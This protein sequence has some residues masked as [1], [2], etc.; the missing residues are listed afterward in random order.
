MIRAASLLI[1]T[2]AFAETRDVRFYSEN[3]QCY[4]KLFLP[5][6]FS[7]DAKV[8]AVIL[9][10]GWQQTERS[11]EAAAQAIAD[12]GFVAMAIDYR[13]WGGSG[14]YPYL[15]EDIRFD[16]RLR[17]S[18]HTAKVRI[19]RKRLIPNDQVD[20][21]RNAISYVQGEPGIDR[22]RIGIYGKDMAAA[23]ALVIAG[24]DPRVKAIAAL[25]PKLEDSPDDPALRIKLARADSAHVLPNEETKLALSEYHPSRFLSQIP[26]SVA[27]LTDQ[28]KL[29]LKARIESVTSFT[30]IDVANF[31]KRS[32]Q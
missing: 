26:E 12:A 4:A 8:P 5:A 13:G 1:A 6:G 21:I 24:L 14:G 15:A 32:L 29:N 10:P 25:Q 18:Q 30:P 23:H 9:A 7:A 2:L 31:F 22:T 20:D 19:R 28:T 16:D 27:V 3:V 17:F 11:L